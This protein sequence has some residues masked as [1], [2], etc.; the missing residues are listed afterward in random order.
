MGFAFPFSFTLTPREARSGQPVSLL[1]MGPSLR[2]GATWLF[3]VSS[4]VFFVSFASFVF[5]P[6]PVQL[7]GVNCWSEE[8]ATRQRERHESRPTQTT[9]EC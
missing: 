4:F 5:L 1:R 9:G 3:F 6:W 7:E 8:D 2:S